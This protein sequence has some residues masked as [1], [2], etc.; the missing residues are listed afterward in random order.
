MVWCSLT[1]FYTYFSTDKIKVSKTFK[2]DA[3]V[4]EINKFNKSTK[5]SY[6]A[7]NSSLQKAKSVVLHQKKEIDTKPQG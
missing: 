7:N 4:K 5:K 1:T 6:S 2:L 3:K